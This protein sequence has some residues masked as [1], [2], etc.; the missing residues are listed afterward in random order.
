MKRTSKFDVRTGDRD[1]LW[2]SGLSQDNTGLS[3][4]NTPPPT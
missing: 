3:Q 2:T 4:D 1:R